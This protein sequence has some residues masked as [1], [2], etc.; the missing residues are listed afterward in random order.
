[1]EET[2]HERGAPP[3]IGHEALDVTKQGGPPRLG[4][5]DHEDVKP[6]LEGPQHGRGLLFT[7]DEQ[8]LVRIRPRQGP[9]TYLQHLHI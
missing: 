7:V 2:V 9:L 8:T 6:E 5:S 1:M 4:I 3:G